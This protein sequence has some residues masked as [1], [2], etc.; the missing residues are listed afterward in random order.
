MQTRSS[1]IDALRGIAVLA[2]VQYHLFSDTGT[3]VA[4]GV[5]QPLQSLF[6]YGWAGVDLFFV[7][8]AYLLAGNLLRNRDEPG[9]IGTF[10]KRRALRIL[11]LYWTALL[12]GFGLNAAWTAAGGSDQVTLWSGQYPIW[13]YLVFVQNWI[14]GINGTLAAQF[15]SAT[16]SLAV[17]EHFYFLLP[18]I[19]TRLTERRLV[20][21]AIV[22]IVMAPFLRAGIAEHVNRIAAYTWSIGRIDSFGWGLLLALA[23]RLWPAGIGALHKRPEFGAVALLP[24]LVA[25][26]SNLT[27]I[28]TTHALYATM[29]SASAMIAAIATFAAARQRAPTVVSRPALMRRLLVWCGQRCFSLYLLHMPVLGLVFLATGAIDTTVNTASGVAL[30]GVAVLLTFGLA[31]LAYR[32]LEQPFMVLAERIAPYRG[33]RRGPAKPATVS[34]A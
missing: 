25:S 33:A 9:L 12:C 4:L 14:G 29:I 3:Y 22:S 18:F 5:P 19:V 6:G 30:V 34:L 7:L 26:F 31:E 10:F 13:A 15:Y 2:V 17:E 32:F 23:P 28:A 1:N 24:V 27:G 20:W 21:L 11:P 8:S 16:W